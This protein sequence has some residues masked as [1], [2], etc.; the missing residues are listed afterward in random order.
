MIPRRD[1][2]ILLL[3]LCSGAAYAQAL[4]SDG[5][6][7]PDERDACPHD[8]ELSLAGSGARIDGCPDLGPDRDGDGVIDRFDACPDEPSPRD[9]PVGPKHGCPEGAL[10]RLD[11][12][13][14]PTEPKPAEPK[15]AE[16]PAGS[17]LHQLLT[18][19]AEPPK[20]PP[21]TTCAGVLL[22]VD[23]DATRQTAVVARCDGQT[24][25]TTLRLP[26]GSTIDG[27][28]NQRWVFT[29]QLQPDGSRVLTQATG[30]LGLIGGDDDCFL[31]TAASRDAGLPDDC[32]TLTTLRAFRDGWLAHQP[33]GAEEIARYEQTAPAIVASVQRRADARTIWALVREDHLD[34]IVALIDAGR[35][36]DAW[37]AYRDLVDD[38]SLS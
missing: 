13:L 25:P 36:H 6:G 15:P 3:T 27:T 20:P 2:L 11:R 14:A 17:R 35:F 4:D 23:R 34:P 8:V 31:T 30:D 9:R 22:R 5:D 33:G 38:L 32:P 16:P 19:P 29:W 12:L 10:S 21:P 18:P 1:R 37:A 7:H 26:V 28:P 24:E